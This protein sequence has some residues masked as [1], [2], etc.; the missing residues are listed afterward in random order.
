MPIDGQP[1]HEC[2]KLRAEIKRLQALVPRKRGEQW[3]GR[4]TLP[5][6]ILKLLS[7]RPTLVWSAAV[8]AKELGRTRSDVCRAL[9]TLRTRTPGVERL[10]HGAWKARL[11]DSKD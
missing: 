7:A 5:A 1:C 2:V 8:I 3:G 10:A 6:A 9:R 11:P 4:P